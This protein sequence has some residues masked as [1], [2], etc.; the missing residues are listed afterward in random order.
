MADAPQTPLSTEAALA[1]GLLIR[2]AGYEVDVAPRPG[3]A[4]LA[5][6]REGT[7]WATFHLDLDKRKPLNLRVGATVWGGARIACPVEVPYDGAPDPRLEEFVKERLAMACKK[8][9]L[10]NPDHCAECPDA[11]H[12]DA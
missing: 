3:G 12:R 1:I 2:H 7:V 5:A 11:S 9:R 10:E 6:A 8:G 4:D